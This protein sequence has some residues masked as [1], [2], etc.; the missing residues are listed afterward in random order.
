M[1]AWQFT[2]MQALSRGEKIHG[3]AIAELKESGYI[4]LEQATETWMPTPEALE[5]FKVMA[6]ELEAGKVKP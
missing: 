3:V 6:R 5:E 4:F 1:Q 2:S